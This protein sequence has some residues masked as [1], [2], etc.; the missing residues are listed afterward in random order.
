LE[1]MKNVC[2]LLHIIN[3]KSNLVLCYYET[4]FNQKI[5]HDNASK[6]ESEM[7]EI[8]TLAEILATIANSFEMK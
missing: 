4:T 7:K 8:I 2:T 5:D 1:A 6:K 3:Y